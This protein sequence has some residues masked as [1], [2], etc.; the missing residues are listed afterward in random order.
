MTLR[1]PEDLAD[2]ANLAAQYGELPAIV[3]NEPAEREEWDGIERSVVR[4][5][6]FADL[7]YVGLHTAV[8]AA[9]PAPSG[10]LTFEQTLRT[11][12]AL[13]G[14]APLEL[15]W[16]ST[17]HPLADETE[18]DLSGYAVRLALPLRAVAIGGEP[19]KVAFLARTDGVPSDAPPNKCM[20]LT[21][22][23]L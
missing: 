17:L 12:R 10:A 21:A 22:P 3:I 5:E 8:P 2:L 1:I 15:F 20:Q 6:L 11:L 4:A 14:A 16:V 13:V 7:G 18:T 19:P 23:Q 9:G